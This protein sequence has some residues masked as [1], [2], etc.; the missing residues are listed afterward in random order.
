MKPRPGAGALRAFCLLS[1]FLGAL[2]PSCLVEVDAPEEETQGEA[3]GEAR[4]ALDDCTHTFVFSPAPVACNDANGTGAKLR[5]GADK[6]ALEGCAVVEINTY[7]GSCEATPCF[8][9]G[10]WP[11][12]HLDEEHQAAAAQ[13]CKRICEAP[14]RSCVSLGVALRSLQDFDWDKAS[15]C[16]DGP[17][18]GGLC[19]DD[20][21]ENP[22][23]WIQES[24]CATLAGGS[25]GTALQRHNVYDCLCEPPGGTAPPTGSPLGGPGAG[26]SAP[27]CQCQVGMSGE[28]P[29]GWWAGALV[30]VIW[31]RARHQRAC[32]GRGP[33]GESPCPGGGGSA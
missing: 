3:L 2:I 25:C 15:R 5:A 4:A 33:R 21:E 7:S 26:A 29:S 16:W 19:G 9:V 32:G 27:G 10:D 17:N 20:P 8:L 22:A 31:W 6:V 12:G 30:V 14:G 18:D 1:L 24:P 23:D 13:E 28:G 11:A